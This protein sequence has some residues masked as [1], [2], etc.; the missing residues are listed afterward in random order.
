MLTQCSL[1]GSHAMLTTHTAGS[2][3][4]EGVA[5]HMQARYQLALCC[6]C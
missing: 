3:Q 5:S 2:P 6:S 1:L 4:K